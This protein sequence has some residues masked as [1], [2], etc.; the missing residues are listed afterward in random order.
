MAII[1][2]LAKLS[3]S[4]QSLTNKNILKKFSLSNCE[5]VHIHFLKWAL[6]VNRKSSNAGVWGE[7]GRY[8]LVFECISLT[9]NY[10]KR[11]QS[12]KNN[13]LVALAFQEQQSLNL[14]WYKQIKPILSID[15]C[16]LADHVTSY[17]IRRNIDTSSNKNTGYNILIH[18]GIPTPLPPQN[19]KPDASK[20]FTPHRIVKVLKQYFK[21]IWIST[22]N[23]SPKLE[24][25]SKY[26]TTFI[27]EDYL[28][29]IQSYNDRSNLTRLRISAHHLAIE[30][31][32]HKHQERDERS[33]LWCFVS[34]GQTIVE[35][36][37]HFINSCDLNGSFR[38]I[39]T[40]KLK[41]N[42]PSSGKTNSTANRNHHTISLI[43]PDNHIL[44]AE[45]K[46]L[47][48]KTISRYI[49]IC[50]KRRKKYL[51]SLKEVSPNLIQPP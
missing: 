38:R 41:I 3:Q 17:K 7:S 20:H 11:L 46:T 15:P 35:N 37:E 26:K 45:E 1:K 51:E 33:C 48:Y 28:D 39:T 5:K 13:S 16:F 27:K 22:I 21:D 30:L 18:K 50:F 24:F 44:T 40:H 43:P 4:K 25:Y 2:T 9:L 10:I 23:S 49:S 12:L 19:L 32:R 47:F 31:G 34:L 42:I 36:E 6:G 29:H 8:P 14:E